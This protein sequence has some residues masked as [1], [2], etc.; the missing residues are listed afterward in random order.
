MIYGKD[1]LRAEMKAKRKGLSRSEIEEKSARI[2]ALVTGSDAYKS[3]DCICVYMAAFNEPRTMG[4]IER[5]LSDGKRVCVP[6][7][8]AQSKTLTLSYINAA[9]TLVRGAY[10]ILEPSVINRADVK[11]VALTLVPGIAFDGNGNRIGFGEGYYDKLL[12]GTHRKK[13]GICYEFQV[14]GGICADEYDVPM[15]M[16]ITEEGIRLCR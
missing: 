4:I 12:S 6:V 2:C 13:A 11:E 8:D 14:C 5:A 7:T 15:D 16:I 10:G 1:E 9:D 3:A